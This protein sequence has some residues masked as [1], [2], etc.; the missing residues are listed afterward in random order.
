[1]RHVNYDEWFKFII[2]LIYTHVPRGKK[3]LELACGTGKI[4]EKFCQIR[5][6]TY[7][8]DRSRHMISVAKER[9]AKYEKPPLLWV[10]DMS[11][12]RLVAEVDAAICLYDSINYCRTEEE[13]AAV[14][15][16]VHEVLRPGG[17]FIFDVC[18]IRNC[19]LNFR[20]YYEKDFYRSTEYVRQAHFDLVNKI[21][22]NEFYLL[23]KDAGD[24]AYYEKHEQHIYPLATIIELLQKHGSW[25][26]VGIFDGFSH[27]AGT[28][29]SDRVHFVLKKDEN[30]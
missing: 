5:W 17:I 24:S 23:D 13:L 6:Q 14:F 8:L 19:R 28:E 25:Q 26:I 29:K 15:A 4:L 7:G 3:V 18:T 1:M 2:D 10:G 21:Q 22:I 27:R 16:C 11:A 12:F 20:N 9:L 30:N